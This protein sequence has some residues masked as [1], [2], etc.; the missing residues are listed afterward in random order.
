[1][2]KAE[3]GG[4]KVR[5]ISGKDLADVAAIY[6]QGIVDRVATFETRTRNAED[7][8][9][10]V[11]PDFPAVVSEL[12]GQ[13]VSVAA[14]FPYSTRECYRGVAEFSVYVRREYRGMGLGRPTMLALISE[15]RKKGIWK[16]VSRVFPENLA[17]RRLLRSIGFREV[18]T[19]VK[20]ARLDGNWKD[21]VIV[22]YLIEE[23][24]ALS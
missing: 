8:R 3:T 2:R 9:T 24:L 18:G 10:W 4:L 6:N 20:H 13:V 12:R 22:E 5:P 1:M 23:N 14:S 16:L 17:S 11:N 15:C 19:Y 21:T 7:M